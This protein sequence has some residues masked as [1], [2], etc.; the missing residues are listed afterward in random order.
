MIKVGIVGYGYWG[1]NLVRNFME[2]EGGMVSAVCDARPERLELVKSRYPSIALVTDFDALLSRKD[3]DALAL[4]TPVSTHASLAIQALKAGKHVLVEKPL[5]HSYEACQQ[6]IEE[7]ERQGLALMVDHTFPYTGAVRKIKELVDS[8]ELGEILYYHSVRVN[9]GLFQHDISVVWDLAVHD[10]S[11]IEVLASEHPI[12]VSA[13]GMSHVEGQPE[14]V[15]YM[16]LFFPGK[17]IAH[18]HVDWLA[19]VKVRQT[20]IGGSKKMVVYNDLEATE[21]IKVY[22][23]GVVLETDPDSIYDMRVGYRTGDMWAPKLDDSE[24]LRTMARQFLRAIA[25]GERPLTHAESGARIVRV[26]E[27]ATE[28]IAGRGALV[29]VA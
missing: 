18:I 26:L 23:H 21:K 14:N 19:P 29:P 11:I 28:S 16:T 6:V 5:A 12:G 15:A 22:D 10:L 20:L 1:P 27:A 13:T 24:A 8:G 4:A 3:V 7:A 17:T 25:T 9:L 2:V